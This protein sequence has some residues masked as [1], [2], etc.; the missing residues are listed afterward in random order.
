MIKHLILLKNTKC[1][2]Y[3]YGIGSMV[4]NFIDKMSSTKTETK[5]DS[6]N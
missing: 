2:R 3:Q 4:Y 1:D 5:F 6:E